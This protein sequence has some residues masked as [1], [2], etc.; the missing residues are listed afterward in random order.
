VNKIIKKIHIIGFP[1]CGS[2]SLRTYFRARY[3]KIEVASFPGTSLYDP[4][5]LVNCG[6]RCSQPDTLS[7]I[8]TRNPVERLWS[9]YWWSQKWNTGSMRHPTF[10]KFLHWKPPKEWRY[11]TSGLIDP[12]D[13]CD[14]EKYM[15]KAYKFN[16]I[17]LRLEDM[18]KNLNFTNEAKTNG[19]LE[20][21]SRTNPRIK[22][23][24]DTLDDDNRK[25]IRE[26]L[27]KAGIPDYN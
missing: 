22:L 2:T 17:I 16:P 13:C 25:L 15:K 26:E 27:N 7:V 8:I 10:E 21:P 18:Q 24:P 20:S 1:K 6:G 9:A 11:V 5:W 23:K 19:V 14:Y 3:P 12:I 4:D